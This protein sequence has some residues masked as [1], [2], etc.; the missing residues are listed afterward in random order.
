MK[1]LS[2][3]LILLIFFANIAL[4]EDPA[5]ES[6]PIVA[7]GV[8]EN[9]LITFFFYDSYAEMWAAI[10]EKFAGKVEGLSVCERKVDK[11]I[12]YCDVY[13]LRPTRVDGW[14]TLTMGHEVEHGV[15]GGYHK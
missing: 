3:I 11:N 15:F 2:K 6:G 14:H 1:T 8:I 12:A 7:D 5:V 9:V 4:A 13:Q 10:P